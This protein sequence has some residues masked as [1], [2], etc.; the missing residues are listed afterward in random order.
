MFGTN[1][2]LNQL[3][4]RKQL[5]VATSELDRA[6]LVEEIHAIVNEAHALAN[7]ARTIRSLVSAAASLV[8]GLASFRRKKPVAAAGKPSWLQT[9][10]QGAGMISTLRQTFRSQNRD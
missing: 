6:Q 5:L 1:P 7:Q 10:L 3:T 2:R 8:G 9:I 4:A